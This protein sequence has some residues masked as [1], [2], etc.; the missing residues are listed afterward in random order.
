[1]E[2]GFKRFFLRKS[3]KSKPDLIRTP[4]LDKFRQTAR[5]DEFAAGP[6]PTIGSHPIKP[7]QQAMKRK[8]FSH[9]RVKNVGTREAR[10]A[11]QL[12]HSDLDAR[13]QTAPGPQPP[14]LNWLNLSKSNK[15]SRT[16][17]DE[18]L[19][20]SKGYQVPPKVSEPP[21]ALAGMS[22]PKYFDL[23]QAA[24]TTSKTRT[25]FEA[26]RTSIDLYNESTEAR[27][28]CRGSGF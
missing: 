2:S 7:S 23:L 19:G 11:R 25:S 22:G 16:S 13:P 1:M 15:L 9:L 17:H 14:P 21:K 28:I 20:R 26:K 6:A 5:Y 12:A 4:F 3:N 8:S 24:V 27:N 10:Q 18:T